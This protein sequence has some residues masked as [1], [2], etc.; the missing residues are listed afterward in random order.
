MQYSKPGTLS[1][2]QQSR[3]RGF[4]FDCGLCPDHEQ[5]SCIGVLEVTSNCDAH[6]PTCY[7]QSKDNGEFLRME[8]FE[9]MLDFFI[10]AEFGQAE[11]LQIS[12]G[13]PTTHPD[14]LE[15]IRMAKRKKIKYVMLNTNGLRIATDETF[16]RE[17]SRFVR[18]FEVYLQFDGFAEQTYQCDRHP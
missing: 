10:D 6:C 14:I 16:V 2:P 1:K 15:I 8:Q 12:G 11:I 18:D 7:A 13:E 3:D 17:L 5:H 9:Q 4:P